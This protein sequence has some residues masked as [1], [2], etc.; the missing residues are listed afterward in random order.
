VGLHTFQYDEYQL[1]QA[2]H[3]VP[4]TEQFSYDA[5]GNRQGTTVDLNNA[6]LEDSEFVYTYDFNDNLVQKVK[7]SNSEITTYTYDN[8]NRLTRV[9]YPGMDAQYQYDALGRRIQK[10]VNGQVTTYIYDGLNLVTDYSGLWTV[11]S[12]YVFGLGL[13]EL[14]SID[15]SGNVYYYHTDGLGSVNELTDAYGNI[16]RTYRYDSFGKIGV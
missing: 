9:Q 14:L 5:V 16:A 2:T 10:N 6:L 15:Q 3:P 11:R 1:T 12:K 13:D 8:E 4:P 7:K